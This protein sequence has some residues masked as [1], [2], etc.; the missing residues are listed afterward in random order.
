MNDVEKYLMVNEGNEHMSIQHIIGL[1]HAFRGWIVK[2]QKNINEDQTLALK[3]INKIIVKQSNLFYS[4]VWQH[5]ND[6]SYNPQKCKEHV[7]MWHEN[8]V[9]KV[10][11]SDKP[12]I[13]RWVRMQQ[14][15]LE[16]CDSGHMQH[17]NIQTM[18]ILSKARSEI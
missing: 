13:K 2:N 16:R 5:R 7:K 6:M 8:V 18:Y 15:D 10:E 17:W 1:K 11:N 9:Q 4:Q 12:E 3:R 14:L